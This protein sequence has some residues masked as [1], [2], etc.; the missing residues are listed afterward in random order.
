MGM[1]IALWSTVLLLG[2]GLVHAEN[3]KTDKQADKDAAKQADKSAAPAI[4]E[5]VSR[6]DS[7]TIDG[8]KID[9]RVSAAT[10]RIERG[11][12]TADVFHVSY[13]RTDSAATRDRPVMFA[14]NGG[15]GSSAVWL[16]MGMLGP[17]ILDLPGDGTEAPRPPVRTKANAHS[18]LDACDLV[19]IDPVTTGYSRATK[20]D[21]AGHFHGLE[22][23]IEAVGEFI[24]RWVTEHDRWGSPKY[25]LGESYGG[26]RAAGLANHLQSRF[27]MSL[28]GV[29]LLSAILDYGTVMFPDGQ[30]QAYSI[31][32]P[33]YAAVAHHH[34]KVKGSRDQ[35]VSRAT[36]FAFTD[37]ATAL[38]IGSD[39]T[40]ERKQATA[41][42][43][44]ELTGIASET[45]IKNNL[46]IEP[47]AFRAE[48]LRD[49]GKTIGRF[50]GRV[51]W[52]AM[53]ATSA[54]A[55]QDPS[56]S[57]ALGAFSTGLK[58]YLGREIGYK[59]DD[60]YEILTGKV[61]PWKWN[62]ENS[63]VNLS[64]RLSAAMRDNP[65]LQVLV[66]SGH[67]DLATPPECM[68]HSLRH[69]PGLP[70]ALR[71]NIRTEFYEAGHMFYLNPPDLAKARK[72]LLRF[73]QIK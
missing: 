11:E 32:L 26:L 56:Y 48:L 36:E 9:Y 44:A 60:P 30:D 19:F 15:P 62:R 39:I 18:L 46:R 10:L 66:M 41:R 52:D 20:D 17:R 73:L 33:A 65:R 12:E 49:E 58:D 29:V 24:R 67:T 7:V 25:L 63:I 13:V 21:K 1:R 64:D 53:D 16:H 23:D 40:L 57:L 6:E 69:L 2:A 47:F 51:A 5:P 3:T 31:F 34:G 68:G 22:P 37:Y 14:F 59:R 35:L 50:D 38:L 45:W 70:P 43:L 54:H 72:D 55:R 42:T 27:G 4:P 28:N 61:H 8:R 71:S